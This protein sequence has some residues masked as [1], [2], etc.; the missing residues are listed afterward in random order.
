MNMTQSVVKCVRKYGTFG[1]RASRSEYWWFVLFAFLFE[2]PYFLTSL[3]G[4]FTIPFTHME[5]T[6]FGET[7]P[8]N[9]ALQYF[10]FSAS[11]L[12]VVPQLAVAS[13]RLHDVGKRGWSWLL[14]IIPVIGW[15]VVARRLSKKG[16]GGPNKYGNPDNGP[17]ASKKDK[18][19]GETEESGVEEVSRTDASDARTAVGN[20][21][22]LE[23]QAV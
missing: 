20:D 1:G 17:H 10:Y 3:P 5:I 22:Q 6:L 21:N 13:R 9:Q 19:K 7:D 11:L 12:L 18:T 15:I 8:V 16:K 2:W 14:V 4:S 23:N